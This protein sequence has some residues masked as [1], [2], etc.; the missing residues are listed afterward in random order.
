MKKSDK[1]KTTIFDSLDLFLPCM[2]FVHPLFRENSKHKKNLIQKNNIKKIR[3][4]RNE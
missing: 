4:R 3:E 1:Y 2:K